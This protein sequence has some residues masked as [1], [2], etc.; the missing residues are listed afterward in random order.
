MKS[1]DLLSPSSRQNLFRF[2]LTEESDS[3]DEG[4]LSRT[5]TH[6]KSPGAC[7]HCKSLKVKCEFDPGDNLCRRCRTANIVCQSRS[8][9]KRKAAPTHE[10]LQEK[11]HRQ[12]CQIQSLLLR[13]DQ[14][15]AEQ[16]I[17]MFASR[18][19]QGYS[20]HQYLI[21]VQAKRGSHSSPE[22]AVASFFSPGLSF[23]STLSLSLSL[24]DD[25]TPPDRSLSV[26]SPPDIVR[27]CCLYPADIEELFKIFFD[28]INP[29]FSI[30]DSEMHTSAKLIWTCPFLFTV[31]C[32]TAS[33]Y[34][35]SKPGLY[36]LAKDFA[37]EAAGKALVDGS[38]SV[39][40]CQAY[41]L[42]GV[43]PSPKKKWAEDR[44]WLLMGVAIRMAQELGLHLPP[45]SDCEEREALNRTRTWLNCYCV[46]GS[47]A[48]QFGKKPMLS[49]DDFMA[50]TSQDWYR[51][52]HMNTPYDVHLC[53]Y[54]QI[55][56]LMAKWRSTQDH[57]LSQEV[58][59]SHIVAQAVETE[60][61]LLKEWLL[62]FARYE[63]EYIRN[64]KSSS[65]W[66]TSYLRLVILAVGFQHT[67]KSGISRQSGVLK[68]SIEAAMT[69]IQIMVERLYPT[70]HL[71]YAMEANFLYVSFSAAYL[72]NLIRP[73]LLP[74]LDENT[75]EEITLTVKR[76]IEVLGSSDVALDGRHTPAVYSRFL[77]N[78]LE[79]Y[80]TRSNLRS[81]SSPESERYQ[82]SELHERQESPPSWPDIRQTGSKDNPGQM[83]SSYEPGVVYQGV[84]DADMDFSLGHFVRTVSEVPGY[85]YHSST[86][87]GASTW[88]EQW[89]AAPNS[90]PETEGWNDVIAP[91][92][93][94]PQEHPAGWLTADSKV[95]VRDST[96]TLSKVRDAALSDHLLDYPDDSPEV[97]GRSIAWK[98][99]L[100]V[101]E[102][103]K[104]PSSELNPE[105]LL[106]SLRSSRIRYKA[107][108]SKK[109]TAPD[110]SY[111]EGFTVPGSS[112]TPS[113]RKDPP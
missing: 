77:V 52:S 71:K 100:I 6:S 9:K 81:E 88:N 91:F 49:L 36:S 18:D 3:A 83:L 37:R 1:E 13:L 84:G 42:L 107:S 70:G 80:D 54:V 51:S 25:P 101:D 67:F 94:P 73:K 34:C 105:S 22:R 60:A 17:Q 103:L 11:A 35:P 4:S 69:V 85:H 33:R 14:M 79:K 31:I 48:I 98:L 53:A 68:N 24:M 38:K 99:F 110:G 27:H 108:L 90:R 57:L 96:S 45:P 19:F 113:S 16:K 15:K 43:Y 89:S 23:R 30:L 21:K 58:I 47:H 29:F 92:S 39:D 74:L 66:I 86:V 63:E 50:R 97:L 75:Q 28:K 76:L 5:N 82:S 109:M 87:A 10:D 106:H 95:I 112:S 46:D 32:S 93:I 65:F 56:L 62:W 44:S 55:L 59:G 20:T 40:I 72:L 64:R 7:V 41:L 102:P 78:L 61:K 2:Q 12:D 111:P 8:R 104:P 26:L